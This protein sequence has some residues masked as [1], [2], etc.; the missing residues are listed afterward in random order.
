MSL[1]STEDIAS[2]FGHKELLL[3]KIVSPEDLIKEIKKI[4]LNDVKKLAKD[5]FKNENLNLA[6]VGPVKNKEEIKKICKF[7]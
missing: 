4:T 6:I 2:F 5:I 7:C 3:G 1:E